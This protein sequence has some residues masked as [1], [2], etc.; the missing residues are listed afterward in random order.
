M[1]TDVTNT[2]D[3]DRLIEAAH[4][5]GPTITA[6]RD[7]IE[8]ERRLPVRL[9]E[10]LHKHGFFNLWLARD[11]GGPELSQTD[12]VRIVEALARYDGSVAWCV[13]TNAAYSRF[14]GFLPEPVARQIFMDDGAAVA[15]NMGSI[16]RAEVV[17]GGYRVSGRWA[18][19]SGITHCEWALGGCVVHD[20]D[21]P[22]RGPG[23]ILET[24]I[25]FFPAREAEV[26]DTWYAGGLRGTASHD[27]QVADLFVPENHASSGR[28]PLRSGPLYALPHQTAFCVPIA[29]VPLG[30]ARAALDGV[31]EL[32]TSKTARI[33]PTLL[34]EK[35]V[36]QGAVGR[37]EAMLRAARAFLFEAC[38]D[39][40]STATSGAELTLEQR[41]AVRLSCAQVA[42]AAKSVVQIAYDIGG[43]TSVY[44]SCPLQRCFRDT[45]AAVQH[46]QVQGGN[47]ETV[48]RVLL[49]MEPGT[50]IL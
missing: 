2:S 8:R 47:F 43:G 9:V 18:Y 30:I 28:I 16:G 45:F 6:M 50:P 36:V 13:S 38:E 49:G 11:F 12:Y 41:A 17:K 42:D 48:G 37:A 31:R 44:E 20:G 1:P 23:G 5:L 22:R 27:Y 21:G 4:E 19:G 29:A 32:S 40:W 26:I 25:A 39:A 46:V 7:E 10:T 35:P 14:S 24:T 3:A 34:R 15:G 33:S